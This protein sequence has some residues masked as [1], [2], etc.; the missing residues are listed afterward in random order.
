MNANHIEVINDWYPETKDLLDNLVA[1]GCK[2]VKG[3]NGE[4][5]FKFD[6]DMDKFIE[7]LTACDE[8]HVYLVTPANKLR[9]IFL[10]YGNSPGELPS[11]YIVDPT[12]DAVTKAHYDKWELIGQPKKRGYYDREQG[13]KFIKADNLPV[14]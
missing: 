1:A 8:S 14:S 2:I 11:D 6:G 13:Y 7:N 5:E 4:D 12:F 3:D 9:W 10:V